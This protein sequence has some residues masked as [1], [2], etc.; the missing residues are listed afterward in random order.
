MD[1]DYDG[2]CNKKG[3]NR[4][5]L[6]GA[7]GDDFGLKRVM[8]HS[9]NPEE[10]VEANKPILK[11]TV[12]RFD[13]ADLIASY[14]KTLIGRCMNPQKQDMKVLLFMLPRIWQVEERVVGTD[15]GLGRFQFVFQEEED[16]A[17]VL[18]ME[19]FHF[20]YWMVSLVR[21][22]PFRAAQTFRSVGEAIGKVQGEVDLREGRVRV[23][24]DGFKP[25]VF[26]MAI[27]FEEGVEIMVSLRYEKLFGFCKECFSMT[28]DQT[29][30]PTMKKEVT[31]VEDEIGTKPV[32]GQQASSYKGAVTYGNGSADTGKE[33]QHYRANLKNGNKGKRIMRERPGPYKQAGSY[34]AYKERL[35]RG[36][37]DGSSFRGRNYGYPDRR[38]GTQDGG[39]QHPRNGEDGHQ[40]L[41]MDA[42]KSENRSSNQ[43]G[44]Q[45]TDVKKRG[46]TPKACKALLFNEDTVLE[47]N[48]EEVAVD[49]S[50]EKQ[51]EMEAVQVQ[52]VPEG[53][54]VQTTK[55]DEKPD[56]NPLDDANLMVEG[57]IL[58]DSELLVDVEEGEYQEW[59][60]GEITDFMEEEEVVVQDKEVGSDVVEAQDQEIE[61]DEMGEEGRDNN[62]ETREKPPKK[63]G[64]KPGPLAIGGSMKMRLVQSL[65]SPRKKNVAKMGAKTGDKGAGASRKA[66][67]KPKTSE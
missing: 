10:K 19:P 25:L 66:T 29:R 26:S 12:P 28:H 20:D 49:G 27:E 14:D 34:H 51:N 54:M 24:L 56:S 61:A 59:E 37:G 64:A 55:E 33:G 11:I 53:M 40:K 63:K 22:K 38:N 8:D 62:E 3:M 43:M 67:M 16:I 42:F 2:D 46:E 57:A 35:P 41:M 52:R 36:N 60:Q 7:R 44:S 48:K 13:N 31:L 4:I 9:M 15:L 65:V 30:C 45:S 23:E 47:V 5:D 32:A 1:G 6:G 50:R 58:S 18:K 17:E 39:F 21:W